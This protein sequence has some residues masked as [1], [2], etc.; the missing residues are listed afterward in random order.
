MADTVAECIIT[1]MAETLEIAPDRITPDTVFD[2]LD[3]DSLVLVELAVILQ[4]EFGVEVTDD[5]LAESET[6]GR[7]TALVK[8][9]LA[10]V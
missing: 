5:E 10:M 3:F 7:A 9:R 2:E 4:R 1:M 8:A 6:V